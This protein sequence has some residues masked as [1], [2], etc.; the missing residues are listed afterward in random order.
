MPDHVEF[1]RPLRL[2]G[3][4]SWSLIESAGLPVGAL[5][6]GAW[7][8][9]RDAGLLAGLAAVW[10]VALI[11]RIATGTVPSL[12]W[13]T[14]VVLTLQTAMVLATGL[15]WIYLLQ[16][17]AANLVMSLLFAWTARG[18]QPLVARLAAEVVALRQPARHHPGLHRFFQ[19]ATWLW[20]GIFLLLTAG[21]G[22][23]MVTEPLRAFLV[24][25]TVVTVALTVAGIAISALWF[26]SV[27]RRSG[28]RVRF[29][30]IGRVDPVA[31][32]GLQGERGLEFQQPGQQPVHEGRRALGGQ[33]PGELNRLVDGHRV[34]DLVL[35]QQ[36]VGPDAEDVPVDRGHPVQRPSL[37]VGG[38]QLVDARPVC[39]DPF[40][41][42][43]GVRGHRRGLLRG[44][45]VQDLQDRLATQFRLEQHIE[46]ALAGL[47]TRGH[48]RPSGGR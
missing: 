36:L 24:S 48:G 40:H 32:L 33:V 6:L 11:R 1:P 8:Y 42:F 10:L 17:P 46:R 27:L 37:G 16:F 41:Q 3:T 28:L 30:A 25:S 39:L 29:A 43:G 5:A 45:L 7:L 12:L 31:A 44:T 19:G 20:A 18:P 14:A 15:L 47:A 35:P 26:R 4:I 2:V 9:G 23:M 22:V 13:I 21:L 38:E 34:G